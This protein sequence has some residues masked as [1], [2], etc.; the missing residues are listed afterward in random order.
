MT[1]EQVAK[2]LVENKPEDDIDTRVKVFCNRLMLRI[3][4]QPSLMSF[5]A[6]ASVYKPDPDGNNVVMEMDFMRLPEE[7]I[8]PMLRLIS[9]PR[10]PKLFSYVKDG[11]AR[12]GV[13]IELKPEDFPGGELDYAN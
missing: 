10:S 3:F 4:S 9:A 5:L 1:I 11:S 6:D 12:T 8:E 7:V 13:K 2:F